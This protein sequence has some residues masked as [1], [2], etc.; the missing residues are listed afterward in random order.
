VAR[1][2]LERELVYLDGG[3]RTTQLMRDS[4]GSRTMPDTRPYTVA[5][6]FKDAEQAFDFLVTELGFALDSTQ[7]LGFQDNLGLKPLLSD[8]VS[9]GQPILRY[10]APGV[11][12]SIAHDSR[13][14]VQVVVSRSTGGH[15]SADVQQIVEESGVRFHNEFAGIYDSGTTTPVAVLTRLARGLRDYGAQWLAHD[16]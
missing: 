2:P 1:R 13:A 15:R 16:D 5:D 9:R 4:L 11:E 10:R 3:R 6:F 7:S 14:E 12:V 8:P